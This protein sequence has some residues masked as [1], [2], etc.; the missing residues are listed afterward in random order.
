[1]LPFFPYGCVHTCSWAWSFLCF[2]PALRPPSGSWYTGS[3][4]F[5]SL[6]GFPTFA[7]GLPL[8]GRGSFVLARNEGLVIHLGLVPWSVPGWTSH[9]CLR[10]SARPVPQGVLPSGPRCVHELRLSL[11]LSSVLHCPLLGF[12]VTSLALARGLGLSLVPYP[13]FCRLGLVP[14]SVAQLCALQPL[15]PSF[16]VCLSEAAGF[17]GFLVISIVLP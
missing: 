13:L 14:R 17:G 1:M 8:R 15:V 6:L 5:S 3:S 10:V 7:M 16:R 4:G 2:L 11:A 12:S 9:L